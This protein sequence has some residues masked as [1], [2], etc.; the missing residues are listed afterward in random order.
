MRVVTIGIDKNEAYDE[1]YA[2]VSFID[3]TMTLVCHDRRCDLRR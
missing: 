1:S 3:V 2:L